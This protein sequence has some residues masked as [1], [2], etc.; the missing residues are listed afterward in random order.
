MIF[1][2]PKAKINTSEANQNASAQ[3]WKQSAR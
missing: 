1:W 3:Q 2:A